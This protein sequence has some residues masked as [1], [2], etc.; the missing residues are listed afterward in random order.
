MN[1]ELGTVV[2]LKSGGPLMAVEE[3]GGHCDA[4]GSWFVDQADQRE[5]FVLIASRRQD[6]SKSGLSSGAKKVM[7]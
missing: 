7:K 2:S 5:W 3:F 1:I 6:L 4:R